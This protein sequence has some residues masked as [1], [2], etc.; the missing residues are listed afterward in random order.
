MCDLLLSNEELLRKNARTLRDETGVGLFTCYKVV[1]DSHN[2][3]GKA[4]TKL[5]EMI[6]KGGVLYEVNT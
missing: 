2:N 6:L 5:K 1:K 4:R 3:L